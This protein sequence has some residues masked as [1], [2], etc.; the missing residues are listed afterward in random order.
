[1]NDLLEHRPPRRFTSVFSTITILIFMPFLLYALSQTAELLTRAFGKP[2]NIIV[3]TDIQLHPV[4]TDYLFAFAQGGEE[5]NDMLAPVLPEVRALNPRYIRIDHIYDYFNVVQKDGETL[6]FDFSRLD[7]A[8]NSIIATGATPVLSLSY[9]PSAIAKDGVIINPPNNWDEWALVV[10][11]TI[12]QYSGISNKNLN[13]VYYEVWNEPDLAQFGSWKLQG[14]KS[15]L[16]LYRYA[17]IGAGNAENVNRF[18]LGGPST[19]GLYRNWIFGLMNS[20]LR[21]DFFSWHS[22]LE[23]PKEFAKDQEEISS[24]LVSSPTYY[25]LPRL[26]TE[27]GFTGAK[28]SRY[29]TMYAAAHA[30]AVFRQTVSINPPIMFA[31]QVKDGPNQTDGWGLLEHESKGK[32]TKPRYNLYPFI[33]E[34]NGTRLELLGEGTWVTALAT[35]RDGV[36]RLMLVNFNHQVSKSENVPIIFARLQPGEYSYTE[37]FLLGRDVTTTVSVGNTQSLYKEIFMPA[38]SLAII[39]L[40]SNTPVVN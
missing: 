4:Q 8:V 3:H 17:A 23:N 36:I 9:M 24:W 33:R 40:R 32:G 11:K 2:A 30:A 26:I 1:M 21:V 6:T 38:N 13:N 15:Y 22:Y 27:Y 39:E 31:F 19:T 20:G 5:P 10:K 35:I 12:E 14:E 7:L 28:D 29:S 25:F 18:Y 16:T 34:M 37:K